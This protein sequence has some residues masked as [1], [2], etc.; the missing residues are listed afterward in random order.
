MA[1]HCLDLHSL[2]ADATAQIVPLHQDTPQ[3]SDVIFAIRL[4]GGAVNC[5]SLYAMLHL[6]G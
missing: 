2:G 5:W 3:H 6:R 4:R 1:R